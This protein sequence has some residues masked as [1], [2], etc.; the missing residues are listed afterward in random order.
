VY[1]YG[2]SRYHWD[3]PI[4]GFMR[5]SDQTLTDLNINPPMPA[6]KKGDFYCPN[7]AAADPTNHVAISVQPLNG[8]T[9]QTAGPTQLAT[10]TADGS[11]N[12]TTESTF[13][14]M[15]AVKYVTDV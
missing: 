4:F 2:S 3:P 8:S 15:T 11:G 9:F 5:N 13:S 12:L 14:N 7:L 6:A 10:Y 1:A